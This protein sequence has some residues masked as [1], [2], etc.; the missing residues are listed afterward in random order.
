MSKLIGISFD[1]TKKEKYVQTVIQQKWK[2]IHFF[3][4]HKFLWQALSP[5]RQNVILLTR[6]LLINICNQKKHPI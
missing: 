2:I 4:L 3:H 1:K 6:L 5:K